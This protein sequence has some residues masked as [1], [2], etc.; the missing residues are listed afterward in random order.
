MSNWCNNRLVITGQSV[1]VDELSNG[2]MAMW[3]LTTIM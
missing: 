1:F 3:F 2:S